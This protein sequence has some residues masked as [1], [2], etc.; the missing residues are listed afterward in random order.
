VN[1]GSESPICFPLFLFKFLLQL[2]LRVKVKA[3]GGKWIS[4]ERFWPVGYVT[5]AGGSLE[6]YLHMDNLKVV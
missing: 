5:I 2:E 3:A 1:S 4:E 6:N